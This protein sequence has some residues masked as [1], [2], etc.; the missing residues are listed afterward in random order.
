MCPF[1][2]ATQYSMQIAH[3]DSGN[4]AWSKD[5]RVPSE[6]V[7]FVRSAFEAWRCGTDTKRAKGRIDLIAL[8]AARNSS[9]RSEK[10][11]RMTRTGSS[12]K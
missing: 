12:K 4:P 3:H 7:R 6:A 8:L 2:I 5:A 10:R 9:E 1:H 11:R